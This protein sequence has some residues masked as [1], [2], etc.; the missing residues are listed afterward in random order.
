MQKT[1]KKFGISLLTFLLVITGFVTNVSADN[2]EVYHNDDMSVVV[3]VSRTIKDDTVT[4]DFDTKTTEDITIKEFKI[5]DDSLQKQDHRYAYVVGEN[6]NYKFTVEYTRNLLLEKENEENKIIE[7]Q[8]K[9][10]FSLDV[11]E[12]EEK[13]E[14]NI[15]ASQDVELELDEDSHSELKEEQKQEHLKT[16]EHES[17]HD[18]TAPTSSNSQKII[19]DISV[20]VLENGTRTLSALP[21]MNDLDKFINEDEYICINNETGVISIER[22]VKPQPAIRRFRRSIGNVVTTGQKVIPAGETITVT[23]RADR[24]FYWQLWGGISELFVNG[25]RAYCLE[26][27]IFD[28]VATNNAS[29]TTLDSV[30]GV[31]V[32]PD[33]RLAFTPSS[34]QRINLELI[35]NYG[36]KYPGH[37]TMR[38]EWATK[39]LIWNEMGWDV[40]GGPNVDTEMAE[41]RSLIAQHNDKPSWH[42]QSRKVKK[43]Q[44]IDLSEAGLNKYSVND[45]LTHGLEI[46]KDS[47]N[48]LKVRV[49]EKDA[50]LVIRK[51]GGSEQGTSYVYSDGHSQKVAHFRFQDPTDANIKF[52][53]KTENISFKKTD[54][55]GSPVAGVVIET[56]Y[57]SDMSGQTWKRTTDKNGQF[58]SRDWE[59][60]RMMYYREVSA[61]A[62]YVVDPT[63]KSHRVVE[64]EN[65]NIISMVN[66]F[67]RSN[68][69]LTKIENDWDQNFPENKGKKLSGASI[70]LY[71]KEDIYEGSHRVYQAGDLLGTKV[72]D[73]TGKVVFKNVPIGQYYAKETKAPEGYVLFQGQWDISIKYDGG[74]PT[75]KVTETGKTVTNQVIYGQAKLIKTDGNRKLLGGVV[76][77]VYRLD[78]TLVEEKT[79]DANGEILT[80]NLRYGDYYFKEHQSLSNYWPD[81]TPV[82]FSIQQHKEVK[83]VTMANKQVLVHLEWSKTNEDGMPLEGVGFKVKNTKTNEFVTLSYADGKKVVEEDIWFTDAQGDVFIKGLIEAGEYELVEVEPLDGYQVIQPLKFTVDNKQNYIDLGA[84]IGLS[85]NV[86]DVVNEWNRGNLKITKCDIDTKEALSNFGFKLY[87]M[88]NNLIGYYETGADGTV[89]ID[90][91]K[92]GTYVVEEVKVGGDYGI[93]PQKARQEVFIEEHG[94]TYEV[95]FENKHADIKTNA[96]FVACDKENPDIVTLVDVVK[97]TDLQVG[98]EYV[99][100]GTLMYKDIQ[101]PVKID[102]EIVKGQTVFTPTSKDGSIEVKF[103]LDASKLEAKTLVVFEDLSREKQSV[104]VHHDIN[105]IDQTVTIPEI[106][107]SLTY[108]NRDKETPN[109]VTLTDKVRYNDLVLG[110]EYTVKG[111]LQD[112]LTGLPLLIDGKTVDGETTFIANQKDGFVDVTFTFDQNKLETEKI[113][114]FEN[115]YEKE[116]LIAVHADLEDKDQTIEIITYRILKKDIDTKEVLKEAE[117]TRY[118]LDG[119]IIEV[120]NTDEKGVVEFKLF[121]GEVNTAKETGAPLGYKLSDEVVTM[122]TNVSEDGSLFVIEYYNELLPDDALPATGVSN[123]FTIVATILVMLGGI[124]IALNK[125]FNKRKVNVVGSTTIKNKPTNWFKNIL[126][127]FAVLATSAIVLGISTVSVRA[128]VI[129]DLNSLWNN[130]KR[131]IG[132]LLT[133]IGTVITSIATVVLFIAFVILLFNFVMSRRRGEDTSEKMMP[134]FGV[135]IGFAIVIALSA[136]GWASLI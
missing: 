87:D 51:K 79:S 41:I 48:T 5:A 115:L 127:G 45:K 76:F 113:V 13:N 15:E 36:Y 96:S 109:I 132:R 94:K 14:T 89:S 38:Y 54:T 117:F 98:K 17:V 102:Y 121:K 8:E 69:T 19:Q 100:D 92:Y 125:L 83:H 68:I 107:T 66:K 60:D 128:D 118:D 78:G 73:S 42:G 44:V 7:R 3:M 130:S 11:D 47:G 55:N 124:F 24:S 114:A 34:K 18:K 86:G 26:P 103:T 2:G 28:Q 81:E 25:N 74:K 71:A 72:T 85:L 122:D 77:G 131:N 4:L 120:L 91:L 16:E 123:S 93:D 30:N 133:L 23:W 12:L 33:G 32:H 22:L 119:N 49:V 59:T 58:V 108:T 84:L 53:I 111:Q 21:N 63:I 129:D 39:K 112:G 40:T 61:P 75:V 10:E 101:K 6:G 134:L 56:S 104:V 65:K 9:F 99:L 64:G 20:T 35:A 37:Q 62:P 105:D 67:Q 88:K 90:N 50:R 126:N 1:I 31:R 110:K 80:S 135:L 46:I 82:Y 43:G 106:G 136:F 70:E 29:F 52:E 57:Q 116:R 97:Y 95:T 27:S